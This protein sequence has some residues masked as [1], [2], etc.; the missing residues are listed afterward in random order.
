M[1][2]A[3]RRLARRYRRYGYKRV[4][5]CLVREGW[6][7]NRKRVRRLWNALGLRLAKPRRK[8]SRKE[9]ASGSSA[10]SCVNRPARFKAVPQK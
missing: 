2:R 8:P 5:A 10:N 7:V 4:H 3:I 9:G 6:E 1:V